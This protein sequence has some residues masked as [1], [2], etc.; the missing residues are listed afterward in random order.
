ML[1]KTHQCGSPRNP[2]PKGAPSLKIWI[3]LHLVYFHVLNISHCAIPDSGGDPSAINYILAEKG[4]ELRHHLYC[5]NQHICQVTIYR[6]YF[7]QHIIQYIYICV[8]YV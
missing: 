8:L 5:L 2:E 1:K 6:I 3:F 4:H 7:M